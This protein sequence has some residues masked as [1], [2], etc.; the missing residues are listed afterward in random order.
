MRRRGALSGDPGIVLWKNTGVREAGGRL[1]R[2]K[3]DRR[4]QVKG[5]LRDSR[6]EARNRD[7]ELGELKQASERA[8]DGVE[9]NSVR[10]SVG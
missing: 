7:L 3:T 6:S 4:R 10:A 8:S 9:G 5:M 2:S 1:R